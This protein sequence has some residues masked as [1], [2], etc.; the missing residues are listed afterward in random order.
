MS[1]SLG[2]VSDITPDE[3][4]AFEMK[5]DGIR[6]LA[7]VEDG[8]VRLVSRNGND[9][10]NAYP[11]VAELGP[12]LGTR[13]AVLDGEIVALH[14]GRPDFGRLQTRMN[15]IRAA[16]VER[17]RAQ[18]PVHF[19]VFDLL[20]EDG[21]SLVDRSYDERRE[22]LLEL[23]APPPR[24]VVQ[25]PPAFEGDLEA[26]MESSRALRL[27]GIVAKKRHSTYAVGRRSRAWVKLKHSSHQEVIIAGWQ[28]GKGRRSS[29]VGSLLLGVPTD[30]GLRYVGK[31]GT[32]FREAE[33]EDLVPRLTGMERDSSPLSDVPRADAAGAHWVTPTLVGEVE[34]AEWTS[35]GRL[36]QPSWRGWRPDKDP[37]D[38][39]EE[40][41]PG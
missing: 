37:E 26:A 25:V 35:T 12:L 27:E 21:R 31:V 24:S 14:Q 36:R 32:G 17:A 20:E 34:F 8:Q 1:A 39:V 9:L 11:E 29:S 13:T 10:T 40:G 4:W 7:Y 22:A 6:A 41:L 33:L 19:L 2:S 28:P 30:D 15:L 16:D 38:V 18:Q 3:D 5:W 23:L